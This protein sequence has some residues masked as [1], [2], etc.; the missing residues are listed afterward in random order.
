MG[1]QTPS[2]FST[3]GVV[4]TTSANG[5]RFWGWCEGGVQFI[6]Y[7]CFVISTQLII[8]WRIAW[9][10]FSQVIYPL[11]IAAILESEQEHCKHR[12]KSEPSDD[13]YSVPMNQHKQFWSRN[14]GWGTYPNEEL[15]IH[16]ES[17]NPDIFTVSQ[18]QRDP[19]KTSNFRIFL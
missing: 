18:W 8:N 15:Q 10:P 3:S 4:S 17:W 14:L 9:Q 6:K 5:R 13:I 19:K 11:F 2:G 7:H 16:K 12:G 1:I